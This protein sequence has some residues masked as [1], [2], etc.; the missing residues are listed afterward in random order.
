MCPFDKVTYFA[1]T[2]VQWNFVF[3]PS[4]SAHKP[5]LLINNLFNNVTRLAYISHRR[6]ASYV[7]AM[8]SQWYINA[9]STVSLIDVK[10]S[11]APWTR[12]PYWDLI[13]SSVFNAKFCFCQFFVVE[14]RL[15]CKEAQSLCAVNIFECFSNIFQH[16]ARLVA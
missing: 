7:F 16:L 13:T 2:S 11:V 5:K 6:S 3:V 1:D 8:E 12:K 15:G 9:Q 10:R 14:R 4:L